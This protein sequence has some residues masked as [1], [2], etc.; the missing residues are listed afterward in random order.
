MFL[1][2]CIIILCAAGFGLAWRAA[3]AEPVPL[4]A[5]YPMEG[6]DPA[7]LADASGNGNDAELI[8]AERTPDGRRGKAVRIAGEQLRIEIRQPVVRKLLH[9]FTICFWI[10][11]DSREADPGPAAASI[12]PALPAMDN[13]RDRPRAAGHAAS[14]LGR[15]P[16]GLEPENGEE[17]RGEEGQL[18]LGR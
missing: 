14:L 5:S 13:R 10:R 18:C 4:V 15:Q 2:R 16:Q 6:A 12:L 7:R 1:V 17:H 9:R 3:A 8:G 11:I